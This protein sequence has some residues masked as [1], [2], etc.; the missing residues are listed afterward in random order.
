M[1]QARLEELWKHFTEFSIQYFPKAVAG[2]ITLIVGWW[3]IRRLVKLAHATIVKKNLD[4]TIA[5]FSSSAISIAFK[6]ILVVTVAGMVGIKTSSL[7]AVLGAAGL[8]VGLA[9]QASLSNL[10]G[11]VLILTF[12]PFEVGDIIESGNFSGKVKAIQLF[13]TQ[14]ITS[15]NK[16]VIIPNSSLSNGTI[17]NASK[18][19][20]LRGQIRFCIAENKHE[21]SKIIS[22]VT[23]LACNDSRIYENP[24]PTCLATNFTEGSAEFTL[25]FHS[26]FDQKNNIESELRLK[27][28][29]EF[30]KANIK[31]A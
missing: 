5:S 26:D 31:L 8:A 24:T 14:L 9:L 22:L 15:E 18:N 19:G 12:K 23:G 4:P 1:V 28:L 17:I 13:S 11:G 2:L 21:T 25:Y 20:N 16:T 3:L 29:E 30:E 7:V 6:V 27:I 10:A